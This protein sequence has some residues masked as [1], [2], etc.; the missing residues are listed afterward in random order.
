MQPGVH[1]PACTCKHILA[2][3]RL[4]NFQEFAILQ[5]KLHGQRR[6]VR[7]VRHGSAHANDSRLKWSHLFQTVQVC[8]SELETFELPSPRK[9]SLIDR[10]CR[11]EQSDQTGTCGT[12]NRLNDIGPGRINTNR[13]GADK[14]EITRH[15]A[16]KDCCNRQEAEADPFSSF[17]QRDKFYSSFLHSFKYLLDA[18][19]AG[20]GKAADAVGFL[21]AC[22]DFN[23]IPK[24]ARVIMISGDLLPG[25]VFVRMAE[26]EEPPSLDDNLLRRKMNL[27]RNQSST[28]QNR[29]QKG[30]LGTERLDHGNLLLARKIVAAIT[31]FSGG[32]LGE[33]RA[34]RTRLADDSS[35]T[36]MTYFRRFRHFAATFRAGLHGTGSMT[37]P[38]QI[39]HCE[40]A[41]RNK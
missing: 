21:S 3:I 26:P 6:Y 15:V 39:L 36:R 10:N 16:E 12:E 2:R 37:M 32:G 9:Q 20:F 19:A 30:R 8:R 27:L 31:A 23:G 28:K 35:S 13:L 18:L 41:V 33:F 14:V 7:V 1:E 17:Q 5:L 25:N 22:L 34:L 29:G 11:P 40:K 24:P 38:D 4:S